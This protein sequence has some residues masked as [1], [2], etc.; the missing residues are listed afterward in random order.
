M[1]PIPA[2]ADSVTTTFTGTSTSFC[3]LSNDSDGTLA[4]SADGISLSTQNSGGSSASFSYASNSTATLDLSANL[5]VVSEPGGFT[6]VRTQS[7]SVVDSTSTSIYSG[8][9]SDT[10]VSV[11]GDGSGTADLAITDSSG[12]RLPPGTYTYQKI[13]TCSPTP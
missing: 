8:D 13:L 10:P 9:G 11:T 5:T 2:L 6:P 12:G 7:F 3:T 4:Q 1:I